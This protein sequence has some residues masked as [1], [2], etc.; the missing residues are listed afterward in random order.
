MDQIMIYLQQ[1]LPAGIVTIIS[2]ILSISLPILEKTLC[3]KIYEKCFTHTDNRIKELITVMDEEKIRYDDLKKRYEDLELKYSQV[4][5]DLNDIAYSQKKIE[6]LI[7]HVEVNDEKYKE[8]N[9]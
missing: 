8:S 3:N 4:Q 6:E 5:K 9:I 7:T 2:L 1:W